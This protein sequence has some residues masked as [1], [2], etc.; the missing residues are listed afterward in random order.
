MPDIIAEIVIFFIGV[1]C[2]AGGILYIRNKHGYFG[3]I[4]VTK[5]E[6][7]VIFSLELEDAPEEL[8]TMKEVWFKVKTPE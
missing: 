5:T 8:E 7:K 2:G 1:L 4:N 6:D 3:V